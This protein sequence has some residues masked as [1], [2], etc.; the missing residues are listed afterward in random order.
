M[1]GGGQAG[2]LVSVGNQDIPTALS[3]IDTLAFQV[4]TQFNTL[5]ESGKDLNGNTGT[6]FFTLPLTVSGSS[7]AITL[8]LTTPASIAA[9]VNGDGPTDG[10]NAASMAALANT[11]LGGLSNLTP[12]NYYSSFVSALGSTVSSVVATNGAQQA[13]L[14]QLQNQQA[15]LSGVSLDNEATALE[16]MEQAY[17]AASKVFTIVSNLILASINLGIETA[18]S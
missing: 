18:A 17:Q 10:T 16:T 6:A 7:A 1:Q 2:G 4:G 11:S 3:A 8:A 13:S 14:A 12:A 9:A 15:A 5:N